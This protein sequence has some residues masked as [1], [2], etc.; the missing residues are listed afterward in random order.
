MH[1]PLRS[2]VSGHAA[3][4]SQRVDETEAD[5]IRDRDGRQRARLTQ[6]IAR[7]LR[8]TPPKWPVVATTGWRH[9]DCAFG[10]IRIPVGE[11]GGDQTP[12]RVAEDDRARD[13][14]GVEIAGQRLGLLRD[15][16]RSARLLAVP[17]PRQIRHV[18]RVL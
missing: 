1:Q 18:R 14:Y 13:T 17:M 10:A 2:G 6:A 8:K 9:E 12:G 11:F 4:G 5:V 16:E 3:K 7:E 15:T